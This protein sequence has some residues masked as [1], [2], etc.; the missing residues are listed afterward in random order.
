MDNKRRHAITTAIALAGS[1]VIYPAR[2]Q[3][4]SEE[5]IKTQEAICLSALKDMHGTLEISRRTNV[6]A[7]ERFKD[8]VMPTLELT[9]LAINVVRDCVVVRNLP[10][11]VA[12]GLEI[13]GAIDNTKLII[14]IIDETD[15]LVMQAEF[16]RGTANTG[17]HEQKGEDALLKL[18][19]CGEPGC[20]TIHT[21]LSTYSDELKGVFERNRAKLAKFK[22]DVLDLQN[23]LRRCA[24]N[25]ED[26]G[27]IKKLTVPT[28]EGPTTPPEVP[29]P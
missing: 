12:L 3:Q 4:C 15:S 16:L 24:A 2:A 18:T 29:V 21:K 10:A 5:V 25:S 19:A 28:L 13:P 23:A 7:V 1:V 8:I 20:A 27:D 17:W 26:C 22:N 6:Q 14:T 9:Q 11:C